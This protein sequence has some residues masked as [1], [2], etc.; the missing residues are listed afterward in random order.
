MRSANISSDIV[1]LSVKP[2][3]SNAA[4]S[5]LR[6][7]K[8][9]YRPDH[10]DQTTRELVN[11]SFTMLC[12][13]ILHENR[14]FPFMTS[15]Y[16]WDFVS[17]SPAQSAKCILFVRKFAAFLD[18]PSPFCTDVIYGSPRRGTKPKH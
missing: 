1:T 6:L 7:A 4:A 9:G 12:V 18:P 17:L 13:E 2:N 10:A 8:R 14:G 5:K 3:A 11:A 16:F 15:T